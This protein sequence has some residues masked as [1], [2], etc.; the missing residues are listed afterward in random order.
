MAPEERL[1]PEELLTVLP[2]L[3][4]FEEEELLTE[5]LEVLLEGVEFFTVEPEVLFDEPEFLTVE[6]EC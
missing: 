4:W 1:E 3:R 6:P 5:E 2:E